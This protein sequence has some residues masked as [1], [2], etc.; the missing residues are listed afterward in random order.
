MPFYRITDAPAIRV[1]YLLRRKLRRMFVSV[2]VYLLSRPAGDWGFQNSC[3][4][5]ENEQNT[6][7]SKL[8]N[9]RDTVTGCYFLGFLL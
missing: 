4:T 1:R 6:P 9:C 2:E 3:V 5:Y 8:G 7:H